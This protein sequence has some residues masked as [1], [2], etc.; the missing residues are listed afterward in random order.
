MKYQY[1][2]AFQHPVALNYN[3]Y[4]HIL[5]PQIQLYFVFIPLH[6]PDH[7]Q[8]MIFVIVN[9]STFNS[10]LI[11]LMRVVWCRSCGC[12][13]NYYYHYYPQYVRIYYYI[14]F[15]MFLCLCV[16]FLLYLHAPLVSTFRRCWI[17][18]V[19]VTYYCESSVWVL[20]LLYLYWGGGCYCLL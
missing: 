12:R 16:S 20:P 7:H 4:K 2:I 10:C 15:V 19:R 8:A 1:D 13:W 17:S 11:L 6:Y 18:W 14:L 5:A 3:L 9:F